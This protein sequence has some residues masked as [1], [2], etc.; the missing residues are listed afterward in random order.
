MSI[1]TNFLSYI[2]KSIEFKALDFKKQYYKLKKSEC[3]LGTNNIIL[4][5]KNAFL[6]YMPYTDSPVEDKDIIDF[7]DNFIK[8]DTL[9]KSKN[10]TLLQ[11][12]IIYK[13]YIEDLSERIVAEQLNTSYQNI[14]NIKR[15]ALK[16]LNLYYRYN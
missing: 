2:K 5:N 11:K 6:D 4:E 13:I 7:F 12:K 3:S 14:N 8:R 15:K 16:K 1:K 10:L 9:K